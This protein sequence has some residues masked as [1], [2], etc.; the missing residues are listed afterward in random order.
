MDVSKRERADETLRESE[1]KWRLLAE[2][3]PNVILTVN[4]DGMIQFLNRTV[5]GF[6]LGDT[7]KAP[8]AP[9]KK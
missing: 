6:T 4:K 7:I 8:V 3:I 2:N 1:R 9:K 5:A